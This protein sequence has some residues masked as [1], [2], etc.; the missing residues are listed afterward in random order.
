MIEQAIWYLVCYLLSWNKSIIICPFSFLFFWCLLKA[1]E[2]G[3]RSRRHLCVVPGTS[4]RSTSMLYAEQTG[5]YSTW[6]SHYS[7]ERSYFI[8]H[9]RGWKND[10]EYSEYH[11]PYRDSKL[12]VVLYSVPSMNRSEVLYLLWSRS[13]I[14]TILYTFWELY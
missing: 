3:T 8:L 14:Y 11:L 13:I 9:T 2:R 4:T 12:H 1:G 5:L 10:T 7:N 6:Y